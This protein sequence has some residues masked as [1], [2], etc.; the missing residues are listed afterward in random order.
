ME[1]LSS[2]DWSF[3]GGPSFTPDTFVPLTEQ[4]LEL[5]TEALARYRGVMRP[6]PHP[7]RAEMLRSLA[8][9]RGAQA[10]SELAEAYM[11]AFRIT[12]LGE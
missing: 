12:T 9:M 11:T 8:L 1:V 5:K 6:S 4:A 2:T 10:G 3:R 7:R